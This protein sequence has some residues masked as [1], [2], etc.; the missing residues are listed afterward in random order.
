MT[1]EKK[2]FRAKT[3]ALKAAVCEYLDA[4]ADLIINSTPDVTELKEF[5]AGGVAEEVVEEPKSAKKTTAK[6]SPTK[7]QTAEVEETETTSEVSGSFDREQLDEMKYNDLKKLAK[8]LGVSAK[9]DRETIIDAILEADVT[10]D[11][12]NT[13]DVDETADEEESKPSK[14][15]STKKTPA[16]SSK[17]SE[18]EED[19]I[20]DEPEV[21][22]DELDEIAEKVHEIVDGMETEEIANI[23]SE[24]GISPKGKRQALIDKII[25]AV[26]NGVLSLEDDE[27]GE[28]DT[29]IDD[30]DDVD[31]TD[32]TDDDSDDG[33]LGV[34]DPDNPDMTEERAE[35]ITE[36]E[37][38]I[39]K[40]F[41]SKKLKSVT[42][43]K[44][45]K[46]F[47]ADDEEALE[48]IEDMDSEDILENYINI[49][50]LFIDDDGEEHEEEEPYEVNGVPYC[51]GNELDYD[52]ESDVFTCPVC[53]TK[54]DGGDE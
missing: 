3:E 37:E 34:N 39:R 32:D 10:T 52:E 24:V 16:K 35:A 27:D 11:I 40:Q 47:Y 22:E 44:A 26:A 25:D 13:S 48:A 8:D 6:K 45:L 29:N 49:K 30:V 50:Q 7:K 33:E 20:D 53:G 54:Y 4:K 36:L 42:M 19:D 31:D 17:K 9:G 12:G 21:D 41:K 2:N 43:K 46:A 23:L 1:E 14:K 5:K 51:C 28:D 15:T 38:T 18:P